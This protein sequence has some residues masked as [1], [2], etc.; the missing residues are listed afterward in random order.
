MTW[1]YSNSQ[2]NLSHTTNISLK[3]YVSKI[4][5]YCSPNELVAVIKRSVSKSQPNN[6]GNDIKLVNS[7][8]LHN[9]S[10]QS[11]GDQ[12]ITIQ[13]YVKSHGK[14]AFICRTVYQNATN[15]F[16]FL[17]TNRNTYFEE[18]IP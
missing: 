12:V 4:T 16:C 2:F 14:H 3:D 7:R 1:I 6:Y 8:Y 5:S 9:L 15:N 18:D 10:L 17:I 11:F 13:K